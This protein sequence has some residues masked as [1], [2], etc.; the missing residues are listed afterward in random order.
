MPD[1]DPSSSSSTAAA[2]AEDPQS[3]PGLLRRLFG[4]WFGSRNGVSTR[5]ELA[6]VL[7]AAA[8]GEGGLSLTERTMLKNILTLRE[9][10][11]EDVMVPRADIIGVPKTITLG[12]LIKVFEKAGHSRL[13]VY[14]DTLDGPIG[15]VHIRDLIAFMA[16]RALINSNDAQ[17]RRSVP[18]PSGLDLKGLNLTLPLD[19]VKIVRQ[20]LFVPPSMRVFDLLTKMQATH[21]HLALVVDEYGGTDGLVSMEDIVEQIVGEIADEHDEE[22]L[23]QVWPQPDG[24]FVVDARASLEDV[25]AAVGETFRIEEEEEAQEVD[26]I[27]GYLMAKGG[28]LPLRGE[29]F[30]GPPGFEIEVLDADPRRIKRVRIHPSKD[31]A[32]ERRGRTAGGEAP[33]ERPSASRGRSAETAADRGRSQ[34][35]SVPDKAPPASDKAPPASDKAPP[36]PDQMAG[37]KSSGS[38]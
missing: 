17:R 32:P 7:E 36:G 5:A 1:P 8:Q 21:I 25:T 10:R 12:E 30:P 16:G 35:V 38:A 11:V 37:R 24:S 6:V 20:L 3:R 4:R 9:R 19:D 29:L 2:T 31:R 18:L 28:R 33:A 14:D 23:P 13:V 22:D 26:T 27:G 34:A 15:M